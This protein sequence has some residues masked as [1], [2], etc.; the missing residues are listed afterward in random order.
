MV[1]DAEKNAHVARIRSQMQ[2]PGASRTYAPRP[3]VLW[4]EVA[5]PFADDALRA[6]P[7]GELLVLRRSPA[8]F[9]GRRYDIVARTGHVRAVLQMSANERIVGYG[10]R[11][12]YVAVD[13]ADGLA[14]VRRHPW[15]ESATRD[16]RK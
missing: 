8:S 16:A 2:V 6:A 5:S 13:D 10:A 11:A 1:N 7:N 14:K 4:P 15:S 9:A 12:I 3:D